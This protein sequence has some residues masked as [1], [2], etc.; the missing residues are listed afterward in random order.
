MEENFQIETDPDYASGPV[1]EIFLDKKGRLMSIKSYHVSHYMY[2]VD[3]DIDYPHGAN[4]VIYARRPKD[5]EDLYKYI[6]YE[7]VDADHEI[8]VNIYKR[9]ID[10]YRQVKEMML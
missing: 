10:D 6:G 9:V 8:T 7:I 4:V 3:K 2:V 5:W 1:L